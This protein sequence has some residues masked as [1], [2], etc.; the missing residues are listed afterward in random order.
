MLMYVSPPTTSA[1]AWAVTAFLNW[2]APLHVLRYDN[3]FQH[4]SEVVEHGFV[5]YLRLDENLHAEA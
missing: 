1:E 5:A 3:M 4:G 2:S